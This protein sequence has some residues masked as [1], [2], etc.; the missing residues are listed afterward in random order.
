MLDLSPREL[1]DGILS[2]FRSNSPNLII[3]GSLLYML[4]IKL[5]RYE[6]VPVMKD[7]ACSLKVQVEKY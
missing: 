2:V 6:A 7:S 5:N 1:V 3:M 4:S